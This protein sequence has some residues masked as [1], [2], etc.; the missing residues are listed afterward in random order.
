MVP[1]G[2]CGVNAITENDQIDLR[3]GDEFLAAL[4]ETI[5]PNVQRYTPIPSGQTP[6]LEALQEA[7]RALAAAA[8]DDDNVTVVVITDG[9][10]NCAWDATA[11]QAVID[12]WFAAGIELDVVTLAGT[13]SA[14]VANSLRSVATGHEP[15]FIDAANTD[16]LEQALSDILTS[17]NGGQADCAQ[18]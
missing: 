2:T 4:D 8:P 16:A 13:E 12:D 14:G 17:R 1:S 11:A 15:T 18:P 5:T 10:P 6:L 3:G 9:V 7:Q